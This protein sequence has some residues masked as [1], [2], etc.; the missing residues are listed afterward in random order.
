M[1]D[2]MTL[3]SLHG[4]G[5]LRRFRGF[6]SLWDT[7]L[8]QLVRCAE[9]IALG[10]VT[11]TSSAREKIEQGLKQPLQP[12]DVEG[13]GPLT[14]NY[15]NT[16]SRAAWVGRARLEAL[17]GSCPKSSA[18]FQSGAR[19]YLGFAEEMLNMRGKELPPTVDGIMAWS[20][21][22]QCHRT[23]TNYLGHVKLACALCGVS[24]E[25]C[26]D[27]LIRRAKMAI[28]KK[29]MFKK[30]PKMW[31]RHDVVELLLDLGSTCPGL[32]REASMLFLFTYVFMLRLPSEALPTH[33]GG[34][35]WKDGIQSA[36][37][38]DGDA[39]VLR[40]LTRKNRPE[41]AVLKRYCWC[42]R[43]P[44]TCPVHV[45]AKFLLRGGEGAAP[46]SAF[47][48]KSSKDELREML[49]HIGIEDAGMYRTHDLRRGHSRDI[50]SSGA[51]L[52]EFQAAGQW[53]PAWSK[54]ADMEVIEDE[55]V[56]E[57]RLFRKDEI[58]V[59]ICPRAERSLPIDS[60]NELPSDL[61]KELLEALDLSDGESSESFCCER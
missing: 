7:E 52:R 4:L 34:R 50:Q 35:V 42:R 48:S 59:P 16:E 43:S 27:P 32:Y 56:A 41:G 5:P 28:R 57:A 22:F 1:E 13:F 11:V 15:P 40:L 30:R 12:C 24:S 46:F 17:L 49:S 53:A 36:I 6:S 8:T 10:A 37:S 39:L 23:F 51:T 9:N 55:A 38:L 31:I 19:N 3:R 21:T 33:V 14:N 44:L 58:T 25:A 54:Y 47:T 60:V 61:E 20:T 26:E 2:I 29:L 45:L 18:S